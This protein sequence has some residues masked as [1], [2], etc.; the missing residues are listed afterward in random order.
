ME[1]ECEARVLGFARVFVCLFVCVR[2]GGVLGFGA[3]FRA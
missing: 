3:E 1:L 2:V